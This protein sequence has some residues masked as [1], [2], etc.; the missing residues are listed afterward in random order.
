MYIDVIYFFVI[1]ETSVHNVFEPLAKK[2][3]SL[4]FML[5]KEKDS[6]SVISILSILPRLLYSN[7]TDEDSPP[8]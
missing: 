4:L 1:H 6:P 5:H 3:P 2:T 7:T 8:V